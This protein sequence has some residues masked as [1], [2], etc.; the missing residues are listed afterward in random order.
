MFRKKC[1]SADEYFKTKTA[2][3]E[4]KLFNLNDDEQTSENEKIFKI[5]YEEVNK[6][7]SDNEQP[8]Y[9]D[10][11]VELSE[12]MIEVDSLVVTR[13]QD[14]RQIEKKNQLTRQNS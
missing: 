1:Q 12:Q 5:E 2:K 3:V 13:R 10:N 6:A 9:E 11:F 4:S 14:Q 7:E 8:D